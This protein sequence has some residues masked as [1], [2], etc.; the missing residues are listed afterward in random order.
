MLSYFES[1]DNECES[2]VPGAPAVRLVHQ[3]HEVGPADVYHH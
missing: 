1:R 3:G 2:D